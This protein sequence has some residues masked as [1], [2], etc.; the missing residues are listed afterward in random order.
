M[1]IK[2]ICFRF[3]FPFSL[4]YSNSLEGT[5]RKKGKL[6]SYLITLCFFPAKIRN[7]FHRHTKSNCEGNLIHLAMF[8]KWISS[9]FGYQGWCNDVITFALLLIIFLVLLSKRRRVLFCAF[10]FAS[11]SPAV[12]KQKLSSLDG[13][14]L[15]SLLFIFDGKHHAAK[16]MVN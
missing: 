1:T 11:F 4:L 13:F 6:F 16:G 9:V 8:W 2:W 10:V 7:C 3:C 15:S 14:T 12:N 5:F